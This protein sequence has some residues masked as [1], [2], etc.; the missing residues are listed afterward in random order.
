MKLRIKGNS[1]RLRLTQM[2]VAE[3]GQGKAV[4]EVVP[5]GSLFPSLSYI[6]DSNA[7]IDKINVRYL[8]HQLMITLPQ[9]QAQQWAFSNL[10]GIEDQVN[11]DN[12]DVLHILIEKDF[13]CLHKRPEEDESDHFL[14]PAAK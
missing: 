11:F 7:D 4:K 3:F 12:G 2:E 5:F 10:V 8:D 9:I 6:I 1:I 14:N 13:Q